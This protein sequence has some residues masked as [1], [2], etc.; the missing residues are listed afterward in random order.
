MKCNR[1]AIY[2]STFKKA[3]RLKKTIRGVKEEALH[4]NKQGKAPQGDG[5]GVPV[6]GGVGPGR[7][8][9]LFF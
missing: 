8:W 5:T 6:G 7:N 3:A 1:K 4:G 2:C 9:E